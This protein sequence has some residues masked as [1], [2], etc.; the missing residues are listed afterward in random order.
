MIDLPETEPFRG[1]LRLPLPTWRRPFADYFVGLLARSPQHPDLL[2][3]LATLA[4]AER[5]HGPDVVQRHFDTLLAFF[6]ARPEL[7][8]NLTAVAAL[9]H[10]PLKERNDLADHLGETLLQIDLREANYQVLSHHGDGELPP[11]W[12][13]LCA[14][15]GVPA[16]FA[17]SKIKRQQILGLFEPKTQVRVMRRWTAR[18]VRQLEQSGYTPVY[19]AH[20]EVIAAGPPAAIAVDGPRVRQRLVREEVLDDTHV[21]TLTP[22]PDGAPYRTLFAVPRHLYFRRFKKIVL[23]EPATIL[24]DLFAHEGGLC[25]RLD[26][27]RLAEL[28]GLVPT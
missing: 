8:T 5:S 25:L 26:E 10:E 27:P 9:P 6:H 7:L 18:L 21:R 28:A 12:H 22:L 17:A 13:D 14:S 3:T 16:W 24:D 4:E 2:A 15:L 11:T 20:D 19:V 23:G 1:L